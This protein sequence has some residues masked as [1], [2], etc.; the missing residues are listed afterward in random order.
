MNSNDVWL[1][2]WNFYMFTQKF[3]EVFFIQISVTIIINDFETILESK[4]G[5]FKPIF[6]FLKS[7]LNP[8][9]LFIS[10]VFGSILITDKWKKSFVVNNVKTFYIIH[11]IK[12]IL[13][14]S[15]CKLANFIDVWI[16]LLSG[17]KPITV[18]IYCSENIVKADF[19]LNWPFTKT[20]E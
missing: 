9:K 12:H 11:D 4:F 15:F 1:F 10:L 19:F 16:P 3:N 17:N 8:V 5:V 13:F 20:N 18:D 6:Y 2:F 14:F 7:I